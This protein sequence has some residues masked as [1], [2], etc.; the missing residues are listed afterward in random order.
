[1]MIVAQEGD[2]LHEIFIFLNPFLCDYNF[3]L[4]SVIFRQLH[5]RKILLYHSNEE[6]TGCLHA[7]EVELYIQIVV[8][9]VLEV[10]TI[11]MTWLKFLDY[12]PYSLMPS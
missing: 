12:L 1:M 4:S 8:K 6:F 9:F 10:S 3:D 5:F 11:W 7:L 2:I